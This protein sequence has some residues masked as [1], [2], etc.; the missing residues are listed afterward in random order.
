M[1]FAHLQYSCKLKLPNSSKERHSVLSSLA[2]VAESAVRKSYLHRSIQSC[3]CVLV[4]F[5]CISNNNTLKVNTAAF[6][7]SLSN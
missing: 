1:H 4:V 7:Q 5:L 2:P 6:F 3:V